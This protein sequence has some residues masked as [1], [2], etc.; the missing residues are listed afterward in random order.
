M[1]KM[2]KV[3]N[4]NATF[5]I[6]KLEEFYNG[7]GRENPGVPTFRGMHNPERGAGA[8]TGE[9]RE[10]FLA[11]AQAGRVTY[12]VYS[13]R[14]PIAYVVGDEFV[15]IDT[16]FSATTSRHQSITRQ[17]IDKYMRRSTLVPPTARDL[18]AS[19]SPSPS[20]G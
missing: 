1:R 11:A 5:C 4:Q 18:T 12:V 8:L 3:T 9:D 2:S 20:R 10:A 19:R 14:T 17:G 6:A 13:Y 16:K 15:M 7:G